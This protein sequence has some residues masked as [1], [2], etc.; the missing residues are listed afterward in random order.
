MAVLPVR[1]EQKALGPH[2]LLHVE[3][4]AQIAPS[5]VARPALG[6]LALGGPNACQETIAGTSPGDTL[7][8][9]GV[10]QIDDDPIGVA[11]HEQC[12]LD[13]TIDVENDSGVIGRGPGPDVL[14]VDGSGRRRQRHQAQETNRED[15][16][17]HY[18][19]RGSRKE[20]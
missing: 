8:E 12:V 13:G 19:T 9:P 4:D 7:R 14:D 6:A 16:H 3:H 15:P 17:V 11:K 2:P 10:A 20:L 18:L 1:L 5:P